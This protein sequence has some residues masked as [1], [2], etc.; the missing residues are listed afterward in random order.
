[1][2][3]TLRSTLRSPVLRKVVRLLGDLG[4]GFA[5]YILVQLA[6]H[7]LTE[8]E[9]WA[10]VS[11]AAAVVAASPMLLSA[12]GGRGMPR[13]VVPGPRQVT[14]WLMALVTVWLTAQIVA[15]WLAAHTSLPAPTTTSVDSFDAMA[16]VAVLATVVAAA[17]VAEEILLRRVLYSQLRSALRAPVMVAALIS[18]VPFALLHGSIVHAAAM[19]PVGI[20]LALTFER[21]GSVVV[22]I[23]GHGLFNAM[24]LYVPEPIVEPLVTAPVM[25]VLLAL[26]ST[27]IAT[28]AI[29]RR[30]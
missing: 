14:R 2:L 25:I 21:T 12:S 22:A 13:L 6:V 20:F 1:M 29:G 15:L 30:R 16:P 4:L 11:G 5:I 7:A 9:A 8:S 3:G 17:P 26:T 19:L 28:M 23:A 10:M 18:A 27:V 24:S